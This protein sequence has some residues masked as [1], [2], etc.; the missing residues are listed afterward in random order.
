[1]LATMAIISM[2]GAYSFVAAAP[3]SAA[4]TCAVSG[5][6]INITTDVA[7]TLQVQV[8]N[9]S[10]QIFVDLG[11]GFDAV[12]TCPGTPSIALLSTTT[13]VVVNADGADQQFNLWLSNTAAPARLIDWGAI[14][15][16]VNLGGDTGA[17]ARD[18]LFIYNASTQ[19][20]D[21]LDLV[22]GANGIDLDDDADV[23][24]TTAGVENFAIDSDSAGEDSISGAGNETT[25]AA[26]TLPILGTDGVAGGAPGITAGDAINASSTFPYN[27][28][29]GGAGNDD[30]LGDIGYDDVTGGK[31]SDRMDCGAGG[32]TADFYD[33]A[34]AV[35][36]NLAAGIAS[37]ASGTDTIA[38]CD[39]VQG[40]A[41][42]DTI[43]GSANDN[44]IAPS[45]G[46]DTV[47]GGTGSDTASYWDS[48]E[49]VEVDLAADTATGGSGNDT[50]TS[51]ENAEGSKKNDTL[52]GDSAS[53]YLFGDNGNDKLN[54]KGGNDD[55]E[56]ETGV[57]TVNYNW[58]DDGVEVR[59]ATLVGTVCS[60]E[61]GFAD[62]TGGTDFLYTIENAKLTKGDDTFFGS[63]FQNKVFPM[64]GQN[65]L[66]GDG[67]GGAAG[68][69]QLDYSKG[70]YGKNGVTVNMAGGATAGDSATG[71]EA[72]IGSNG[73][74]SFTGDG[75]SNTI[76]GG[77]GADL[78]RG[79]SGDDDLTGGKGPDTIVAGSG[80]DTLNGGKGRDEG[81]GGSGDDW[82]KSLEV[83]DS[84]ELG[85]SA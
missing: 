32:G 40:S 51:I 58:L 28:L 20:A 48:K 29:E 9:A 18:R 11:G 1:M 67:C 49:A 16:T 4:A 14:N 35:N 61:D 43:T 54:G 10:G 62:Y 45:G 33:L 27:W 19:E 38:N 85:P 66:N 81:W 17:G 24:V 46:D 76:D 59:L 74:D 42:G 65:T 79:G 39:D 80:D 25:G 22:L 52:K 69:D 56:G 55:L 6:T 36:I 41:Q 50:L 77:N 72:A 23:D 73:D 21:A 63:Q 64:G 68:G 84:I 53:N 15:F 70:N 7:G 78:I 60:V 83:T 5:G 30:I 37:S 34:D 71:F 47:N 13:A 2:V 8:R 26:F 12:N 3:A 44:W 31:G 75:Q 57:D 82:G